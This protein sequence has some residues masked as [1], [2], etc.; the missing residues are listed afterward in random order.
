MT[1]KEKDFLLSAVL[2]VIFLIF[3]FAIFSNLD[4]IVAGLEAGFNSL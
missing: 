4:A 1:V 2:A 3:A